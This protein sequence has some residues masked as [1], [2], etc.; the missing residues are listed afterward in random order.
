M[1]ACEPLLARITISNSAREKL[2]VRLGAC[3]APHTYV[4]IRDSAGQVVAASPRPPRAPREGFQGQAMVAPGESYARIWCLTALYPFAE[5]GDYVVS[6]QLL[7]CQAVSAESVIR[8]EYGELEVLART[9]VQV[10]VLP[11][12]VARLEARCEELFL[13]A[14]RRG[15]WGDLP[16]DARVKAI[17]SVRHDTVLPYLD[18]MAREWRDP[19]A[20]LA[21][22]RLGT[23][24][25]LKTL[26]LYTS[27]DNRWGESLRK[28]L[29]MPLE[30]TM[31]DIDL[32][33]VH[34]DPGADG[35][36]RAPPGRR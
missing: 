35:S 17:L 26:K 3:D 1:T 33:P 29:D 11:L 32:G 18:W 14:R 25:A 30:P 28:A 16:P 21:M 19:R 24:R 12:D 10:R 31:D 6:L 36:K 27:L 2:W 15:D 8:G 23:E 9:D 20:G 34:R 22:R 7:A 5:P 4:E 13:P